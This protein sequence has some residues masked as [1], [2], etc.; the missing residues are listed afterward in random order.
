[1]LNESVWVFL[2]NREVFNDLKEYQEYY[3]LSDKEVNRSVA[4]CEIVRYN[5]FKSNNTIRVEWRKDN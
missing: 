5:R 1:M 3:E 4:D 2:P